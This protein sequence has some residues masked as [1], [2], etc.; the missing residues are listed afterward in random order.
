MFFCHFRRSLWM[1]THRRCLECFLF[2][3][4]RFLFLSRNEFSCSSWIHLLLNSS[5]QEFIPEAPIISFEVTEVLISVKVSSSLE[6][7][8]LLTRIEYT[9]YL[10]CLSKFNPERWLNSWSKNPLDLKC[11]Y[12]FHCEGENTMKYISESYKKLFH[13]RMNM[14]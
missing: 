9:Q 12:I 8:E 10:F 2:R 1:L 6:V 3:T 4:F 7:R 13:G 5:P 11:D 14:N